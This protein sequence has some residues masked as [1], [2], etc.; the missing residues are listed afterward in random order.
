MPSITTIREDSVLSCGQNWQVTLPDASFV[1]EDEVR[2]KARIL[3]QPGTYRAS[4]YDC[5]SPLTYEYNVQRISC[6]CSIF[7]PTAFSPNDDGQ[8][9]KLE[10]FSSCNIN[11]LQYTIY[12]RWGDIAF[13]T[14]APSQRWDGFS[15]QKP[16]ATG[17]YI[18]VIKYELL[19]ETGEMQQGSLVQNVTLVR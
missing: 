14:T 17:V 6:P 15:K 5:I 10:L 8:N 7:L 11:K 16:A 19:N 4:N 12:N 1:W 3:E 9:D 18:A 2:G 13:E